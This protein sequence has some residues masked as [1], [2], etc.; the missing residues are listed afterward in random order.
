MKQIVDK[1]L[2]CRR[3]VARHWATRL[4]KA[5]HADHVCY[6]GAYVFATHEVVV[7]L[8]GGAFFLL[9]A[10]WIIGEAEEGE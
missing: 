4:A 1:C 7:W 9:L 2:H 8:A 5:A 3:T 6:F 10:G